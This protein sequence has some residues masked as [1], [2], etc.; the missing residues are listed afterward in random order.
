MIKQWTWNGRTYPFDVSEAGC[1]GR[2]LG[3]LEGLRTNLAQFRREQ[4]ADVM[5]SCHCGILQEF[6]DDLF[7]EG[8]G[9][10]LC[11]KSL[12]A[13]A[14]SSAYIDFMDLVNGQIDALNRLREDAEKRYLERAAVLGL[15]PECAG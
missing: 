5:L 13:E 12:S 6:F 15:M 2:L 14:Y 10:A 8:A 4:D 7:G 3:A 1:M 9:E 11:G